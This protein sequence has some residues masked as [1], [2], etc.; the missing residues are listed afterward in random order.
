MYAKMQFKETY[1]KTP[2][3][4]NLPDKLDCMNWRR[5]SLFSSHQMKFVR[6]VFVFSDFRRAKRPRVYEG[7]AKSLRTFLITFIID[8]RLFS[9]F[10]KCNNGI[11]SIF[12]Q[13]IICRIFIFDW[14]KYIDKHVGFAT[15]EH[16][17]KFLFTC[18]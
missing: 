4:N 1:Y 2:V 12:M 16:A 6:I 8:F 11:L 3:A 5:F 14:L 18:L 9:Y 13:N 17:V 15:P 7:R 10:H